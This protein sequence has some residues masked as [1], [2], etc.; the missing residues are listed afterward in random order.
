[1][2]RDSQEMEVDDNQDSMAGND[3]ALVVSEHM[4]GFVVVLLVE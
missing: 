4:K 2:E 1:M 3:H